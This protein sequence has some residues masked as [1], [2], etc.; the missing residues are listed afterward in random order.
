MILQ[1]SDLIPGASE[2]ITISG[3]ISSAFQGWMVN[4]ASVQTDRELSILKSDNRAETMM[5]IVQLRPEMSIG[6]L[7]EI[8]AADQTTISVTYRLIYTN[9][10]F[11]TAANVIVTETLPAEFLNPVVTTDAGSFT[12]LSIDPL[13]LQMPDLETGASAMITITGGVPI[14]FIGTLVNTAE[15]RTSGEL[16]SA[17]GNNQAEL[18]LEILKYLN[19]PVIFR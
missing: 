17:Q 6:K 10:G 19:F 16:E 14:S 12:Q 8:G 4:A 15:I 9:T 13:V 18:L 1:M 7:G 11:A 3:H 2:I 5:D